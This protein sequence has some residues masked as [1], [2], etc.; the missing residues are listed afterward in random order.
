MH[1]HHAVVMRVLF[2]VAVRAWLQAEITD[3]E[4][5]GFVIRADNNLLGHPFEFAAILLDFNTFPGVITWFP[6]I[7]MDDGHNCL[8]DLMIG[9]I[10]YYFVN[11]NW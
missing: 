2:Q 7:F 4:M 8:L 6:G 1:H 5:R 10:A 3:D 11:V 9:V